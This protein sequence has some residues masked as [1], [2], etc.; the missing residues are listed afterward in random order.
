MIKKISLALCLC[1]FTAFLFGCTFPKRAYTDAKSLMNAGDYVAAEAAFK[2]LGTYSDSADMAKE[3]R[4]QIGLSLIELGEYEFARNDLIA[5]G[6]Y[7]DAAEKAS[8][9]LYLQA[10]QLFSEGAFDEAAA[11]YEQLGDYK[12]AADKRTEC[13][14]EIKYAQAA[15]LME[16]ANKTGDVQALSSVAALYGELDGYKDSAALLE[17]ACGHITETLL[18]DPAVNLTACTDAFGLFSGFSGQGVTGSAAYS[19]LQRLALWLYVRENGTEETDSDGTVC[20]ML[21]MLDKNTTGNSNMVT[22]DKLTVLAYEGQVLGLRREQNFESGGVHYLETLC[23]KFDTSDSGVVGVVASAYT[24]FG[25][26]SSYIKEEFRGSADMQTLRS[27]ADVVRLSF[28]QQARQVSGKNTQTFDY[29]EQVSMEKILN[30]L[31]EFFSDY[32]KQFAGLSFPLSVSG[33][34]FKRIEA[35]ASS[36][37]EGFVPA[38]LP[39][40]AQNVEPDLYVPVEGEELNVE[41]TVL[42][43]C[44]SGAAVHKGPENTY[45]IVTTLAL[46]KSVD[47]TTVHDDWLY[48]RYG[49]RDYGWVDISQ[50]F[51]EWM[52]ESDINPA[53]KGITKP[54]AFAAAPTLI[55]TTD[56]ANA[57][58]GPDTK[59]EQIGTYITGSQGVLI[60][61]SGLWYLLNFDGDYAWVH[62]NNFK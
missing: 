48:V 5:L 6:D 50:V 7:K 38:D 25:I 18:N 33:M 41:K 37:Q 44:A 10:G 13:A 39:E 31:P 42:V 1:L 53:L 22:E 15:A 52:F 30:S 28:V 8:E 58:S 45:E 12:D 56:K 17:E 23:L 46:G 59:N 40:W 43:I 57:R 16:T 47:V 62:S 29:A 49:L 3:C 27:K 20:R 61:T 11:L 35:G 21:P 26:Y 24:D 51:G 4:Y 19:R 14:N 36:T 55:S 2:E 34:G 54:K 32:D 60:G 9:C